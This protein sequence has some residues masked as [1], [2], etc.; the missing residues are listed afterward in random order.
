MKKL[1][2]TGGTVFVSKY[3]AAWFSKKGY[4]VFVLNRGN[5]EQVSGVT[6]IKADR[7]TLGESLKNYYFDAVLDINA[8]NEIDIKNLLDGIGNFDDYIFIS[9]GAVYPEYLQQPFCEEQQI[10]ENKISTIY[11][12]NKRKAEQYLQSRVPQAYIL[13]PCYLYGPMQ[14]LYREP[15][16]F[17]CAKKKRK[18]YIP[19]DGK[20]ILQFF[21]VEDLCRL[22][23]AILEKHPKFHII[24]A[25][26]TEVVDINQYIELCYQ[27]VGTKL[28][29]VFVTNYPNQKDYFCFPEKPYK[30]D[31]GRQ[32]QLLREEKKIDIGLAESYEW[33]RKHE[34]EVVRKEYISFI[35]SYLKNRYGV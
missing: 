12:K 31:T 29:K 4:E 8:Y 25:G 16:V 24:N 14:N 1:L 33:Y 22:M 35:D 11:G 27:V 10:E 17:E 26:N 15:F 23:E 21:H 5:H 20:K 30:L 2:I 6:L 18:F 7:H 34:T 9:S 28:E 32:H 13:R 19:E 3:A